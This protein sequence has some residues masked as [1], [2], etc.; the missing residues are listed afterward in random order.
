MDEPMPDEYYER[1]RLLSHEELHRQL[2]AGSPRRLAQLERAWKRAEDA[3]ESVSTGLR[4]DLTRL[5]PR[6]EGTGS[7]EFQ[8]R[9]GLVV[10]FAQKLGEEAAALRIGLGLMSGGLADAQRRADQPAGAGGPARPDLQAGG[11]LD[12]SFGHELATEEQAK[13]RERMAALVARLAG[14]YAL[15]D[16]HNWP[17]SVPEPPPGLPSSVAGGLTDGLT[18]VGDVEIPDREPVETSVPV[19]GTGTQLAG[20]GLTTAPGTTPGLTMLANS[21]P[22]APVGSAPPPVALG[23]ASPGL[24]GAADSG[25]RATAEGRSFAAPAGAGAGVPPPVLGGG[26]PMGGGRPADGYAITDP[27]LAD[28][29]TDWSAAD[30]VAW[31]G[32]DDSPP[33]VLGGQPTS[34]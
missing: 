24:S 16:H 22:P 2:M 7:R 10:A 1:Y 32:D 20:A 28:G 30:R 12:G 11:V 34:A 25:V 18:P 29:A 17:A 6:W 26:G 9:I 8:F 13:A 4:A 21:P 27:R 15:A 31:A 33:A 19:T 23:G 3:V 5:A 14:E